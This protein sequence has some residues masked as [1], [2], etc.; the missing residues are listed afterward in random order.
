[1]QVAVVVQQLV[2]QQ[3]QVA[4]VAAEQEIMLLQ[5]VQPHLGKDMQVVQMVILDKAEAVVA[6]EVNATPRVDL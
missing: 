6:Q 5:E 2:Q 1:M 4:Q 3:A